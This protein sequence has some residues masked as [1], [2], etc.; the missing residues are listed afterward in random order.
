MASWVRWMMLGVFG[1]SQAFADQPS[2]M[3]LEGDASAVDTN[4]DFVVSDPARAGGGPLLL[5]NA[6]GVIFET[7]VRGDHLLTTLSE[8]LAGG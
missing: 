7:Y 3:L 4:G 8:L 6:D 1:M 5:V 2:E